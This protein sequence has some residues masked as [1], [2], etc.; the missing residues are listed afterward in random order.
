MPGR[1]RG[2]KLKPWLRLPALES[3]GVQC[4]TAVVGHLRG[5]LDK[6][7]VE[8]LRIIECSWMNGFS[9]L[10]VIGVKGATA[11]AMKGELVD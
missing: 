4:A 7:M 10:L 11:T 1:S 5:Q 2:P 8:L 6:A 9:G 3:T